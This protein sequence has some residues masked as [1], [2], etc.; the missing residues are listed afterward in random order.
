[1]K[2]DTHLCISDSLKNFTSQ[3]INQMLKNLSIDCK[4][5]RIILK[6]TQRQ[7]KAAIRNELWEYFK[8]YNKIL[9]MCATT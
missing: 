2:R 5:L 6:T 1:M 9:K 8:T 3:N 4:D 7:Q